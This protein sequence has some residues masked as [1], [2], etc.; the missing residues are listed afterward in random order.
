MPGCAD[1]VCSDVS[2]QGPAPALHHA[3]IRGCAGKLHPQPCVTALCQEQCRFTRLHYPGGILERDIL[4]TSSAAALALSTHCPVTV[5]SSAMSKAL[6]TEQFDA[7][8]VL[9]L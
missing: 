8:A 6:G 2:L 1:R 4:A 3:C 7:A 5:G 9:S